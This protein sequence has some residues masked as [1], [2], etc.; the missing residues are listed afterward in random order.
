M[1]SVPQ[2]DPLQPV[3]LRLQV[4]PALLESLATVTVSVMESPGSTFVDAGVVKVTA[5]GLLDPPQPLIQKTV[6]R[7]DTENKTKQA[8]ERILRATAASGYEQQQIFGAR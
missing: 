2:P 8:S 5:M 3:P 6:N 7:Q 1:E 4:T